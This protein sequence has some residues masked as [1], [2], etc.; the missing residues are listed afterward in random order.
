MLKK[1][2]SL[3]DQVGYHEN[4][5]IIVEEILEKEIRKSWKDV[6]EVLEEKLKKIPWRYATFPYLSYQRRGKVN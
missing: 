1:S 5:W 4:D 3:E 6:K 2:S